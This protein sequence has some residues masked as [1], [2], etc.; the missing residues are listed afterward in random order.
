MFA[1][2]GLTNIERQRFLPALAQ[3]VLSRGVSAVCEAVGARWTSSGNPNSV[4]RSTQRRERFLSV[5]LRLPASVRFCSH[6]SCYFSKKSQFSGEKKNDN[7]PLIK[8]GERLINADKFAFGVFC[9][10][11]KGGRSLPA[12]GWQPALMV[13]HS[14][15]G[16]CCR[17]AFPS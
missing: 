12:A 9:K 17:A 2:T 13:Q 5:L 4:P 8:A 3:R 6:L 1:V 14:V 10:G 7:L 16:L 15:P 11:R